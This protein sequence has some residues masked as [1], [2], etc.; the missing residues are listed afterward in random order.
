MAGMFLA[1]GSGKDIDLFFIGTGVLISPRWLVTAAHLGI[2]GGFV[3]AIGS[4]KA[5]DGV[6]IK[7]S[8]TITPKQSGPKYFPYNRDI[9]FVKLAKPAPKDAKFM[10]VNTVVGIP[11][12][13]VATRVAGYG[14]TQLPKNNGDFVEPDEILRHVDVPVVATKACQE[15]YSGIE[16]PVKISS[17]M[18][19]AGVPGCG[20]CEADS[21]GP[22]MQFDK[23]G[24]PVLVGIVS[25]S[26]RCAE[27]FPT[28]YT[29]VSSFIPFMRNVGVDFKSAEGAL[30][31]GGPSK[32]PSPSPS[33]RPQK[34]P[35]M[36]S[37]ETPK[38]SMAPSTTPSP[39]P[40]R[41]PPPAKP[42][43][44]EAVAVPKSSVEGGGSGNK[45]L[46]ALAGVGSALVVVAIL[47]GVYVW[48]RRRSQLWENFPPL[49]Y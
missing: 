49:S 28:I 15:R 44:P 12:A 27:E 14:Y 37:K 26:V 25:A 45:A 20:P 9:T 4:D 40:S 47:G 31:F 6:R 19:C 34:P 23:N 43:S 48:K 46:Y 8:R 5:S 41:K 18:I 13:G 30:Q 3:A 35:P 32:S 2:S 1:F 42:I 33:S 29:R 38:P 16:E 11:R 7:V 21:G 10:R 22:L 24:R 17:S 36:N 39:S